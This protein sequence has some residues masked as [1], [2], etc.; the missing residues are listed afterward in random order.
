M[1]N[2]NRDDGYLPAGQFDLTTE[3]PRL[4]TAAQDGAVHEE[5]RAKVQCLIDK[6]IDAKLADRSV[7]SN[8]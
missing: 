4:C 8:V 3:L 2:L 5:F 6:H 7:G 1:V